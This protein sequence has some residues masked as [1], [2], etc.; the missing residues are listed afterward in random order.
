[1]RRTAPSNDEEPAG[2]PR[3]RE[4]P[5]D[6]RFL[7][8]VRDRLVAGKQV[9]RA[10][11]GRGRL[12]VDRALPFLCVHRRPPAG[13]DVGTSRL[14]TGEASYLVAPMDLPRL[15]DLV[16]VVATTMSEQF[17]AFIIVEVWSK[18]DSG[19]EVD[20]RAIGVTAEV[21][22]HGHGSEHLDPTIEVLA[23]Q[24]RRLEV[25]KRKVGV[26][27]AQDG[28]AGTSPPGASHLLPLD[29][30]ERLH[31]S[32]LGLAVP[33]VYRDDSVDPPREF[34]VLL[35]TVR[36]RLGLALRRTVH[37][38]ATRLTT[39]R[40][41]HYHELGRRAVV[42][43]VWEVDERLARVSDRFDLLLCVTPVNTAAAW[44]QFRRSKYE[45]APEFHYLPLP[46]D[47]PLLKRELYRTPVERVEDP[48]LASL[49]LEKQ[50]ELD[51]KINL[52]ADRNTKRFLPGSVQIYGGVDRALL[53]SAEAIL[54]SS[55]PTGSSN[56]DDGPV[57]AEAF[58]EVAREE[59]EHYRE[60][61]DEFKA[62]VEVTDAVGGVMVSRGRLLIGSDVTL[63]ADRVDALVQHEVGVHLVTYYNGVLQPFRQLRSG[64]AG[65]EQ[66]QE[67][68]AV[69][70]E[71]LVGGLGRGRLRQLAG[72]VMAVHHKEEGA[73]FVESFRALTDRYG[74]TPRAAFHIIARVRRGGGFTKDAIYLRGLDQVLDLVHQGADLDLLHN[75]KMAAR[76][77][78]LLR[79]LRLREVLRPLTIRPRFLERPAA[80]ERLARL[81][82]EP[83]S[84]ARLDRE[85]SAGSDG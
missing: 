59:I 85:L 29:V 35:K 58:A 48:A 68:L 53:A 24:L 41:P 80:I 45:K 15:G 50:A 40:P 76:H 19:K 83:F 84:L 36:R 54:R 63:G 17:G 61:S 30:A 60:A 47:P 51:R 73:S 9:R 33:P 38:F 27:I 3:R 6:D 71:F 8:V 82:A 74:F 65:Y 10:L 12:H 62:R 31:C 16:E 4:K 39:H 43:A 28:P 25:R 37:D 46:F 18:D 13:T 2:T 32:F 56:S 75:G 78:P 22:I 49:F 1:M 26:S 23:R 14:V 52:L 5:I 34:P 79:E 42:K 21:V 66:L 44:R 67:G 20:P 81:R 7:A 57:D 55:D 77:L 70:A 11:P 69:L 64:L 72:R